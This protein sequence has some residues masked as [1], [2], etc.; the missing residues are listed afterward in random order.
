MENIRV[1]TKSSLVGLLVSAIKLP[2]TLIELL[3]SL[4]KLYTV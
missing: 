1:K 2:V 3:P 4:V